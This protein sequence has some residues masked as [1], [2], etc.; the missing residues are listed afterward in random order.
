[1]E[2]IATLKHGAVSVNQSDVIGGGLLHVGQLCNFNI[3]FSPAFDRQ[4]TFVLLGP[5]AEKRQQE[6]YRQAARQ[7]DLKVELE[8][9]NPS[10]AAI[11]TKHAKDVI[12]SLKRSSK[13]SVDEHASEIE[14]MTSRKKKCS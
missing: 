8:L 14:A 12:A 3:T 6:E 11:F 7:V 1:M 5:E 2:N 9:S 13:V 4:A 10:N